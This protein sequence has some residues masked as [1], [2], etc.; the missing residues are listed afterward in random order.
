MGI[1]IYYQIARYM[2]CPKGKPN[3]TIIGKRGTGKSK[4][5]LLTLNIQL[6]DNLQ[7]CHI[8]LMQFR[9]T[10]EENVVMSFSTVWHDIT[11]SIMTLS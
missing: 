10:I 8:G 3:G 2:E 4:N 7:R 5:N 9:E 1:F 11:G 6:V